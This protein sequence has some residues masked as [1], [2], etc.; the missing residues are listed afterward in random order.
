MRQAWGLW[1]TLRPL[2][3]PFL[4][5]LG[6]P[7][8]HSREGAA[9]GG[10]PPPPLRKASAPFRCSPQTTF[11]LCH[12]WI[13][14]G[15]LL[16]S[17]SQLG[18]PGEGCRPLSPNQAGGAPEAGGGAWAPGTPHE[19]PWRPWGLRGAAAWAGR[20]REGRAGSFSRR[21][22]SAPW[23]C[24][25]AA[26][27]AEATVVIGG[28][29]ESPTDQPPPWPSKPEGPPPQCSPLRARPHGGR[30]CWPAS[31][32]CTWLRRGSAGDPTAT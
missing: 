19:G 24:P 10:S 3:P 9:G 4:W 14:P 13:S 27:T 32:H 28:S 22:P 17:V 31:F 15:R 7:H 12:A 1:W 2:T 20:G 16:V 21:R 18:L 11:L 26:L 30:A 5:P 29:E 23:P 8:P 6:S 25:S